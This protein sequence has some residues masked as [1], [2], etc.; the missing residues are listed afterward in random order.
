M[1]Y[2]TDDN[3]FKFCNGTNWVDMGGGS[4]VWTQGGNDINYM[5]G[6]VG[7]GSTTP[8]AKLGIYSGDDSEE[9][10]L[11]LWNNSG[12]M[13]YMGVK[14]AANGQAFY[15]GGNG[16]DS[17]SLAANGNMTYAGGTFF[18]NPATS[19]AGQGVQISSANLANGSNTVFINHPTGWTGNSI[20]ANLNNSEVWAIRHDGGSWFNGNVGIGTQ[21][22]TGRLDIRDPAG[23][24][25]RTVFYEGGNSALFANFY[26]NNAS[27]GRIFTNATSTTY[28]TTS[29]ARLKENIKD[30]E[31]GIETLTRIKVRDYDF[32]AKPQERVQGFIAQELYDVYPA[33]VTVGGEDPAKEPWGVEY[34]RLTPLLIK[35]VQELKV[36]NDNQKSEIDSISTERDSLKRQLEELRTRIELLENVALPD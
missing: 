16:G 36:S 21:S 26:Y 15:L 11:R 35:S 25:W 2:L 9:Q 23:D 32:I 1:D 3:T 33:A 24:G 17:L 20:K 34:G 13:Y 12:T 7:I 22:P 6:N 28:Q 14:N 27:V 5:A 18:L 19:A 31:T 30:T 10:L 8:G 4:S 29:D